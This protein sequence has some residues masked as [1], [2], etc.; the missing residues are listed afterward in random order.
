MRFCVDCRA[1]KTPLDGFP[2]PQVHDILTSLY[3]ATVFSTL[4]LRRG[5]WQ[6]CMEASLRLRLSPKL[7]NMNSYVF[8]L[9]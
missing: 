1:L 6:V 5:Y 3:G 8:G 9:G 7:T 2:M 4:H